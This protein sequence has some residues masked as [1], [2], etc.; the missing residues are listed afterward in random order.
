MDRDVAD[1]MKIRRTDAMRRLVDQLAV[2]T[3]HELNINGVGDKI[4]LI[5]QTTGQY[6]DI[7]ERLSLVIRLPAWAS[8]K[9]D[10]TSGIRNLMSLIPE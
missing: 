6:V 10:E 4:D 5:R 1:V 8:G 2:R 9:Q 7:L 3:G